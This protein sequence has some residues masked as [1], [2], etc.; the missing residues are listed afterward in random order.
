MYLDGHDFGN[1]T[2]E[3]IKQP[4]IPQLTN[5]VLYR[6]YALQQGREQVLV[7][8]RCTQQGCSDQAPPKR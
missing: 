8:F 7:R 2:E 6:E 1:M 4:K 5:L 3:Q